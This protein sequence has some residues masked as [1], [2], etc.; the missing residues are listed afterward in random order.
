MNIINTLLSATDS[1]TLRQKT[2]AFLTALFTGNLDPAEVF[3]PDY[4]Q[5]TD[6]NLLDF[7]GFVQHLSHVRLHTR[8]VTFRVVQACCND[9]LLADRHIVTVVYPGGNQAEIE[10]YMFAALREGKICRI[11]EVTRLISGEMSDRA[12]AHA[13]H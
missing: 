10:V 11:D 9:T 2:E 5:Y 4:Q 6:G 1:V 13:T 3:S 8:S 12:L 7:P